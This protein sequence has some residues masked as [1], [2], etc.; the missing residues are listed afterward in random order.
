MQEDAP[1][2]ERRL[3]ISAAIVSSSANHNKTSLRLCRL[4]RCCKIINIDCAINTGFPRIQ[5]YRYGV[6]RSD[7]EQTL[8][9]FDRQQTLHCVQLDFGVNGSNLAQQLLGSSNTQQVFIGKGR[10]HCHLLF[11]RWCYCLLHVRRGATRRACSSAGSTKLSTAKTC[12][13]PVVGF[14]ATRRPSAHR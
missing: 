1:L 7:Q 9:G 6:A 5:E 14:T 12:N 2:R 8:V 11:F 10:K 13:A 3:G 4:D